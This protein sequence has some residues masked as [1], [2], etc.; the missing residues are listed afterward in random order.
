[1]PRDPGRLAS[2]AGNGAGATALSDAVRAKARELGFGLAGITTPEPTDHLTFYRRWLDE[3][4]HGQ[5]GYLARPDAVARRGDLSAT[6]PR[7][8]SVVVVGH[9]Y[10]QEDPPGVPDDP[11]RGVIAR[12]ARGR[13]YHKVV[14]KKLSAL[15][16]WLE[17]A[18]GGEASADGAAAAPVAWRAYVDTGPILERDLGRRAGLGWFGK[19]TLLIHPKKGSYFFLGVLLTDVALTPDAPFE[20]DHCGSCRACLDACPTGALLGLDESGAPVMDATRCISYL[21]IEHRG[22]I[23]EEFRPVMGNRVFGC[24]ICQEVCP[25]NQRF[26]RVA[27]ERAY[28]APTASAAEPAGAAA[29]AR[30]DVSAETCGSTSLAA[31]TP[32]DEPRDQRAKR[33]ETSG[34]AAARDGDAPRAPPVIPTTDGPALVDLMRMS[35][36]DW[37]AYTRGSA[38]RRPGYAGLRRNVAIALGNRLATGDAPDRGAVDELVAAL[39]DEDPVVVRAAAWGLGRIGRPSRPGGAP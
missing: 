13:D 35:E 4:R 16:A 33:D 21:T 14:K 1:M 10:Y 7:V 17:E 31:R 34:R 23:P 36:D 22:E 37:D 20:A 8:R 27:D 28:A 3:G 12:Y 2:V 19:N 32:D 5:M 38:L 6:L 18:A 24:D 26:A 11:S 15:G 25:W 29:G 9:E 39:A 30:Q